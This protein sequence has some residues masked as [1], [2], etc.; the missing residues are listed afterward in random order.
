MSYRPDPTFPTAIK[1]DA[2]PRAAQEIARIADG[3]ARNA[4]APWMPRKRGQAIE[5]EGRG[6]N[7]AVTNLDYAGHLIEWGSR[8]NPPHAPLRRAVR[9]AGYRLQEE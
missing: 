5:V 2:F 4:G 7:V 1:R 3:Y 6:E 8:N 9:A